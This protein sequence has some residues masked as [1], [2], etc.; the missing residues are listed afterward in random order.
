MWTGLSSWCCLCVLLHCSSRADAALTC[1]SAQFKCGNGR[2]ITHKW[3]CD[4]T[5]DCGDG[6]D[7]LP[8]V[9]EL[10]SC[11]ESQ[12]N[13][14]APTNECI[15]R[16][17]HCDG[18]ADC[19][20]GAD[21]TNCT[22]KL[23]KDD[24]FQC[25]SGQCVSKMFVCDNEDDCSDGSD[26]KS[27]PKPTCSSTSFQCNNLVCVPAL[28]LCDGDVDCADGSDEWPKNCRG[29][30]PEKTPLPC[31]AQD[32]R[33]G[34]G[35]CIHSSWRCDGEEDCSDRSD[36]LN[37]NQTSCR[38]DQF[39]CNNG[40]CI[41]D[42]LRCNSERDC[43]DG[44]DELGCS[45]ED[46]CKHPTKFRCG[47]GECIRMDNVCDKDR[48]CSDGSDEPSGVCGTNECLTAN[49]GCAHECTDLKIGHSCSCPAGYRLKTD[50]HT[51]EDVDEC[52]LPDV[53]GQVCINL[54]GSFK[55]DCNDGYEMDPTSNTCKAESG[56]VPTLFFTNKHEV[57]KITVDRSE[58]VRLMSQLKNAVALDLDLPNKK[59][60]WSDLSLKKIFSSR[61]DEA[62]DSSR[63]S[64]VIGSW[65]EAPEG[66]AVDW[67]HGNIY[68]TDSILKTVSVA[69]TDGSKRRTLVTENLG[70]PRA[71]TVDPVNN[72][73]YWTDW[74]E[75]PKIEKCGLNGAGRSVL[76]KDDIEWPNGI[77]LDMVNQRLYWADSKLH[78][79]SSID[80][81]GGTRHTVLSGVEKLHRPF[82]LAVFEEKVFWTDA[83]KSAIFSANRWTG[84]DMREL[85]SDVGQPEDLVLHHSLKQPLGVNWC[86]Q[87]HR[88][89]AG[90]EFLCLPAPVTEQSSAQFTCTCPDN[91]TLHTDMRTCVR[92][93]S[94]AP[95]PPTKQPTSTR[96]TSSSTIQ[97]TQKPA[98]TQGRVQPAAPAEAPSSHP[99]A[100]YVALPLVILVVVALGA[101]LLWRQW[102]VK[103]ANTIHFDNPVYQK[104]T[105]DELHIYR[106]GSDG[107]VYPERQMVSLDDLDVA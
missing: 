13:C 58:Y 106:N 45:S 39:R 83:S 15:P 41:R 72:F 84:R 52:E 89:G 97:S 103:S 67:I 87:G 36:E 14:G 74:G 65:I 91:A 102:R 31:G 29:K 23:C 46:A 4:G 75:E 63:H 26:E 43:V 10:K 53:C 17:W 12:F 85:V 70:K 99:A 40:T 48:D 2:C 86:T 101:V 50:N 7:E 77:T 32:F 62:G 107:Y 57:R 105:E 98:D 38:P 95:P 27:C 80:V 21:E 24:Q 34:S 88:T 6:S 90:C 3:I 30:E 22:A 20:N 16:R 55:C 79:I 92:E 28:W 54:P 93:G 8:A 104:T 64:V 56:T 76:V 42:G 73:M 82:S 66:V 51:C 1:T 44:S 25:A 9:C 49:G 60:F 35:S 11:S 100:L 59:I 94:A 5:D 47:S 71:I 61:M 68:W 33:C 19:K 37:C 81:N 78:T 96:P 69:T 18:A